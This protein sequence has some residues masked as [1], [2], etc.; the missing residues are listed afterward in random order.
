LLVWDKILEKMKWRD[1]PRDVFI[2]GYV[3]E[4]KMKGCDL[5]T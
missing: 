1:A 4:A 5:S 3:Q 2:E